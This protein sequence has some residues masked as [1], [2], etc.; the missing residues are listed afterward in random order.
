[1]SKFFTIHPALAI[2]ILIALLIGLAL[3]LT[4]NPLVLLGLA[5]MMFHSSQQVMPMESMPGAAEA[6]DEEPGM[7]FLA[8]VD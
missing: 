8:R 7:G 3:F 2:N 6:E 5:F 4:E 1:M